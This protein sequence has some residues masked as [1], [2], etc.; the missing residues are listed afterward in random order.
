MPTDPPVPHSRWFW[1]NLVTIC[2]LAPLATYWFQQHLQL[3][4][5]EIVVVG[6][7]FTIWALVR[8]IW[9][10]WEK[11]AQADA[12]EISRRLL[13]SHATTRWLAV[14]LAV[15]AWLWFRT[16]SLYLQWDGTGRG[17]TYQVDVV[18]KSDGSPFLTGVTLSA[19]HPIVGRPLFWIDRTDLL[20]RIVQPVA[21]QPVDCSVGPHS[22]TRIDVPGA[23]KPKEYHLLRIVPTGSLYRTLPQDTD[24]PVARYDLLI[25]RGGESVKLDDLR[26]Q[27]VLFGAKADEMPLVL[28]L[29]DEQTYE[30][31]LD[32]RLRAAGQ[33]RDNASL[34]A[35][36]LSSSIRTLPGLYA[37]AGDR[38]T[39]KVLWS[40]SD[41]PPGE[42]ATLLDE[43]PV[44]YEVTADPV[45]TLWLPKR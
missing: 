21:Y 17:G 26:R 15:F 6:G 42:R 31:F 23:F 9:G 16:G 18:R 24:R 40:R 19:G 45:Q 35:A 4:V 29:Q 27:T 32:T 1:I 44:D 39:I 37:K 36:I 41:A 34:T 20:C 43:F 28:R 5:T 10:I 11:A 7:A 38:L 33:D 2:A 14:A 12:W 3:Y 22:S 25:E 8:L 30:H 13:S